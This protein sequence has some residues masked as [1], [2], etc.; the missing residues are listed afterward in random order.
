MDDATFCNTCTER[1]YHVLCI[2]KSLTNQRMYV[3]QFFGNVFVM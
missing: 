2:H 1:R 3:Q